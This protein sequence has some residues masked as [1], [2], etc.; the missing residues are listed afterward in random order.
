MGVDKNVRTEIN[1]ITLFNILHCE[2]QVELLKSAYD[3]LNKN[4]KIGL[5]IGSMKKHQ[6][7]PINGNQT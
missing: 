4:G 6:E 7:V 3:I 5:F 1:Y 2:K